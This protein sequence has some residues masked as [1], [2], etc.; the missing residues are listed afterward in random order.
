VNRWGAVKFK[1][2]DGTV[3]WLSLSGIVFSMP[4]SSHHIHAPTQKDLELES[5]YEATSQGAPTYTCANGQVIVQGGVKPEGGEGFTEGAVIG[6]LEDG[7]R[8]SMDLTFNMNMGKH[9][10]QVQVNRWGAV[11]FKQ[12][13]GTVAW[14]SLSGIVFYVND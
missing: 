7:C 14:L 11:K 2:S 10:A 8:P 5:S 12:S 4:W 1:Q 6:R 9:T 3:A 13:D